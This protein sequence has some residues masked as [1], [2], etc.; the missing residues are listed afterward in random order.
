[1]QVHLNSTVRGRGRVGGAMSSLQLCSRISL[2]VPT[3]CWRE[4]RETKSGL[5]RRVG[6]Y[7]MM[8][9]VCSRVSK[10]LE[11]LPGLKQLKWFF[12]TVV[13]KH[14]L[15]PCILADLMFD[16]GLSTISNKYLAEKINVMRLTGHQNQCSQSGTFCHFRLRRAKPAVDDAQLLSN[17]AT[18]NWYHGFT[19]KS[20]LKVE[21]RMLCWG[22]GC[23]DEGA[24][25]F[26]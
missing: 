11:S 18:H 6:S 15:N 19:T 14:C 8:S 26:K 16:N 17:W 1:M 21:C 25:S 20:H 24:K 10:L 7:E 2:F 3:G 13:N 23:R 4:K 22:I 12:L 9:K 5:Y